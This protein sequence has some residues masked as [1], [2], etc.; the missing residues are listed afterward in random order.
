MRE[1]C[2]EDWVVLVIVNGDK[3]CRVEETLST[4]D[5]GDEYLWL[6]SFSMLVLLIS[7]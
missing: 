3:G 7:L 1:R 5:D 4:T 6:I 2:E